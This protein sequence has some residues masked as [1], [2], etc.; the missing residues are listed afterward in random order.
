M[1]QSGQE[2]IRNGNE[3]FNMF[4]EEVV[5]RHRE[6]MKGEIIK[7]LEA[8]D[9]RGSE[10]VLVEGGYIDKGYVRRKVQTS[11]G[12]VWVRIKRLKRKGLRGS[13]Y[14]LFGVCGV[15]RVSA[16][17]QRNCVQV[18][19]G[20]SYG[21]SQETLEQLSGMEISRMGIWKVVQER[22]RKERERVEEQRRK[23]FERGE[24]PLSQKPKKKSVVIQIDGTLVGTRE[25]TNIEEFKGK[26]RMEVKLGVA[27]SGT[28]VVSKTR[29]ETVERRLYGEVAAAE[30]FGERWYGECL[31]HGI[32]PET[33][34]QVIGDGAAWIR[35]LQRTIFPGS[36]YTLDAYH[37]QKAAREVLTQ[38]QYDD[39]RSLIF[40]NQAVEALRY[41][42]GL[43]PSDREHRQELED[44]SAYLE[45]NLDGINY[46]TKGPIG[47]GVVEKIAD[48][49]VGRRMKHRGMSWSRQGANNLLALRVHAL[50]Q[51]SDRRALAS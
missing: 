18:A 38:R 29:R 7:K 17:A 39:F 6:E 24:I 48:I 19:I 8:M 45:R 23:V 36:R 42:R 12:V 37:L 4:E 32:D 31:G 2:K 46:R 20:Q 43:Y 35:N 10:E 27:F 33:R 3:E 5:R 49:V 16:R 30:E 44:F 40:R 11:V 13:E 47:S 25:T 22:G 21:A 26:R 9:H 50:N 15:S 51:T 34:V 41:V 1:A 14:A 28:K